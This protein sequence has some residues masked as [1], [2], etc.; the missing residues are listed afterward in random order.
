MSLFKRRGSSGMSASDKNYEVL[1][2]KTSRESFES[3]DVHGSQ[4]LE[5]GELGEADTM[6]SRIILLVIGMVT[7]GIVLWLILSFIGMIVNNASVYGAVTSLDAPSSYTEYKANDGGYYIA[8]DEEGNAIDSDAHYDSE[9]AVPVPDWYTS[10]KDEYDKS[11]AAYRAQKLTYTGSLLH[12]T[13][14]KFTLLLI[15]ELIIFGIGYHEAKKNLRTQNVMYDTK[16]FNQHQDDQRISLPLELIDRYDIFPDAGCSSSV[17]VTGLLSHMM[18]NNKGLD[19][20]WVSKRYEEDVYDDAGEFVE[21]YKGEVMLD[22]NGDI[23]Y[24][25]MP[26][27]DE[28]FGNKLYDSIFNSGK[29]VDNEDLR[30]FRDTSKISYNPGNKNRDKLK[31][32]DTVAD[33]INNDWD[34]EWYEVQRPAGFYIVDTAP[35]NFTVVAMTRAGK[36][37]TIIEPTIDMWTREKRGRNIVINDPKGGAPRLIVKSYHLQLA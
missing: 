23:I 28:A 7:A 17:E 16:R 25:L 27:V 21:Y 37:Q 19:N 33:L 2:N 29:I 5:R 13:L 22:D 18:I 9:D 35:K 1:K 32:Y 15:T 31:G 3:R 20:I 6:K 36:G 14:F 24:E 12:I 26:I 11:V 34:F 30:I 8:L 4:H 10:V